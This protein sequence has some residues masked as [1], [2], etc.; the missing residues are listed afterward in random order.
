MMELF[1]HRLAL[2]FLAGGLLFFSSAIWAK[3]LPPLSV[4]I[5]SAQAPAAGKLFEF[6]VTVAPRVDLNPVE[7]NVTMPTGV[8]L[9]SGDAKQTFQVR[10]G[11]PIEIRYAVQLPTV[12]S[13]VIVAQARAGSA[14]EVMFSVSSRYELLAARRKSQ[15]L[16]SQAAPYQRSWRGGEPVR[17]YTLP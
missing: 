1:L 3:P 15:T 14:N 17:E 9:V 11:K 7:V 2:V 10:V 16:G 8:V 13:G 6:T 4:S 5:A 12:L